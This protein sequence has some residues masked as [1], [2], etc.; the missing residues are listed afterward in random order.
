M[1]ALVVLL[2]AFAGCAAN[3][4]PGFVTAPTVASPT[5]AQTMPD[6]M[7]P[8]EVTNEPGRPDAPKTDRCVAPD[9]D[10]APLA[11]SGPAQHAWQAGLPPSTS[12]ASPSGAIDRLGCGVR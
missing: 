9:Q 3:V 8:I 12:A 4:D 7:R 10:Q 6:A 11:L 1:C 2:V 5:N